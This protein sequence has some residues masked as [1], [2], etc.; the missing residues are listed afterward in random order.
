MLREETPHGDN[1]IPT[2]LIFSPI[3]FNIMLNPS[4]ENGV[5]LQ[6]MAA[7]SSGPATSQA[8]TAEVVWMRF[9]SDDFSPLKDFKTF[10]IYVHRPNKLPLKMVLDLK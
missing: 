7:T 1:L 2:F 3:K 10:G 8:G 4:G 5:E 9:V 6:T